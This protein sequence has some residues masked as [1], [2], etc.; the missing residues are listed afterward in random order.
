MN[1][2]NIDKKMM[3]QVMS[4]GDEQLQQAVYA[5]AAA[6]GMD[7]KK[8]A[9]MSRDTGNIRRKLQRVTPEDLQKLLGQMDAETMQMLQNMAS[10]LGGGKTSSPK[11]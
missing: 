10:Q 11:E 2:P 3:D 4:L 6:A 7:A 5:L 1:E 8:A 9:A